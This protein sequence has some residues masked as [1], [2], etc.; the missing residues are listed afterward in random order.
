MTNIQWT[1]ETWNPISGCT[2]VSDGCDH[3]YAVTMTHRLEAMRQ[4][5]YA[6]LTVLNP[7]GDRHFNGQVRCHE[8]ALAIPLRWKKPRRIFVNSM[9]DLFHKDVPFVFIDE[10]FAV[11]ALCPQHTF[12]ILTKRPERM[13]EY[14]RSRSWGDVIATMRG[15]SEAGPPF[16]EM[17]I[18]DRIKVAYEIDDTFSGTRENEI[19]GNYKD[20]RSPHRPQAWPLPNV[21]LGTSTENQKAADERIPHL[22][23]CPART[24]F[25]S[26]EPLLGPVALPEDFLAPD[27]ADD[28]PRHTKRMVIVGGESGPGARPMHP[29]WARSL[30]DQCQ[31][32][33]TPFF[34]KQW[35]NFLPAGQFESMSEEAFR[36][37]DGE[38]VQPQLLG[39]DYSSDGTK[40][41]SLGKHHAGRLLDGREWNEMPEV[42]R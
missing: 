22:L 37:I 17:T 32:F 34:F 5:K 35:G 25:L 13:A 30:R 15:E 18:A 20:R 7:K 16:G 14:F 2:R 27:F 29:D 12:Q 39:P 23:K 40:Y 6:G 3:C 19:T 11:M 4:S 26:I 31:D 9:S 33:G 1:D 21:W 41:W 36:H 8:D 28:D 10:V 42:K 24:I 38:G